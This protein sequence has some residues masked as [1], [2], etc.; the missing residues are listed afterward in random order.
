MYIEK[1]IQSNKPIERNFIVALNLKYP[2]I[3]LILN[4]LTIVFLD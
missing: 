1:P 3:K 4:I 2:Q